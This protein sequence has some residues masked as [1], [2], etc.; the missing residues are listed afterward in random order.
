MNRR[1]FITLASLFMIFPLLTACGSSSSSSGNNNKPTAP[2]AQ[3]SVKN[4]PAV[5]DVA[6]AKKYSG[7]TLKYYGDAVGAAHQIDVALVKKF[8]SDTGIKVTVIPK[9]VSSTD[10]YNTYARLFQAHSSSVD[11]MMLDVLWPGAFAPYLYDLKPKLGSQTSQFSP[12]LV[13]NDTINGHL[14][15]MPYFGDWGMLY[16]RTDLLKKYSISGPPQT[17]EQ[18]QADALKIQ[19]GEKKK[20]SAFSGFVFQGNAYEGLTCDALEWLESSGAGN[21]YQNGKST[22]NNPK[23]VK[24]LDRARGWIGTISPRGVTTYI[25][26]DALHVFQAGNAAFMRNWPYAYALSNAKGSKVAG[27]FKVG[28]L[29]AEPGNP[30]V[31]TI[32]GWQLGINK[33]SAHIPAAVEFVRYMTSAPVMRWRAAVGSFVPARPAV[34]SD[35]AVVKAMPFLATTKNVVRV[36]RPSRELGAKYNQASTIFFQGVS[37]ILNGASAASILPAVSQQLDRLASS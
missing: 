15:A 29:P 22:V 27:K 19:T 28:P 5:A 2:P 25:E 30:H 9:P 6:A 36:T 8:Q 1:F 7:Q 33:Y 26:D 37:R 21:F 4:P 14:V 17:W 3:L 10:N 12:P 24:A 20:N 23:A 32:G 18:L 16:Y 34:L 11:A 13:K 35:P 31:G